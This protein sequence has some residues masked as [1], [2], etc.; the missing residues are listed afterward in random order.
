VPH[1]KGSLAFA[2]DAKEKMRMLG[3]ETFDS[4]PEPQ[5]HEIR[6]SRNVDLIAALQ[7]QLCRC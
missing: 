4:R 3:F 6:G 1:P 5:V 7:V 2:V